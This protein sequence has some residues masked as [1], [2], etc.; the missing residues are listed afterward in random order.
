MPEKLY[1][2]YSLEKSNNEISGSITLWENSPLS[3]LNIGDTFQPVANGPVLNVNK[4]SISDNVIGE[5]SGKPVRQWQI[6][7]EG[8]SEEQ[9]DPDSQE[10]TNIKY[11]FNIDAEENSGSMEVVNNGSAPVLSLHI[12]D[13]FSIPGIGEVTCNQVRGSDSFSDKGVHSWTV[14][15]EGSRKSESESEEEE[16][17]SNKKYSFNIENNN[18]GV[19][20]YS[21]SVE[22]SCSG[23]TPN[24]TLSI[25]DTFSIPFAGELTCT[26]IK[27]NDE[28]DD[29]GTHKWLV[30]CEGSR[31]GS[32]S[33]DGSETLPENEE[34]ISY[35]INGTTVRSVAGEFIA[36][37]RSTTPITK[38]SITI[39]SSTV[40]AITTPGA[41]Y[42]GGIAISENISREKI[43]NS[44]YYYRHEIEVEV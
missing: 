24:I 9:A 26:K 32:P 5:R 40:T 19:T 41:Q 35:E 29:D 21:G 8:S 16:A 27:A 15:Y 6:T 14:I 33:E 11:S 1:R 20:V 10:E 7:I 39:Y 4:V 31:S 36:L 18:D 34:S 17:T 12:G 37:R 38:K 3:P 42:Q 30:V 2:S 44:S 23:D 22:E 43:N 28:Y 25:G 13:T